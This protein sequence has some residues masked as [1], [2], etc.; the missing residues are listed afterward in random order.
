LDKASGDG[1]VGV[2]KHKTSHAR[3]QDG[4][5]FRLAGA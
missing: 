5:V 3:H 4:L 2:S 1:I